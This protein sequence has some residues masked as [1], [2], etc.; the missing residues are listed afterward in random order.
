[1][2]QSNPYHPDFWEI[3][4]VSEEEWRFP[5]IGNPYIDEPIYKVWEKILFAKLLNIA[6]EEHKGLDFLIERSRR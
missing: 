3:V 2:F 5:S 4:Q 6:L 1:M